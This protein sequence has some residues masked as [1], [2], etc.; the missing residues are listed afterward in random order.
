MVV[1]GAAL[2]VAG[3]LAMLGRWIQDLSDVGHGAA[4][5]GAIVLT[6]A[7][8]VGQQGRGG[9]TVV[10]GVE[11]LILPGSAEPAALTP[12]LGAGGRRYDVYK[13]FLAVSAADAPYATV[14]IVS[15]TTARLYYGRPLGDQGIVRAGRRQVRLPVC[16]RR[17]S[18]Y[19]GGVVLAA[20]S[21][22]TFEVTTPRGHPV[23]VDVSIGAG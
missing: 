6:C 3:C 19:V 20:P 12:V 23:R 16:G 9:E 18:G 2:I 5:S 4:R 21:H 8:S 14:S 7:D 10:G 11:G 15:P 1:V 17:F 22:V 13:A